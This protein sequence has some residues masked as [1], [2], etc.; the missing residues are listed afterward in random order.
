MSKRGGK[1]LVD[2][3]MVPAAVAFSTPRQIA[4]FREVTDGGALFSSI[5]TRMEFI[6]RWVS[7][8]ISLAGMAAQYRDV[9]G[10]F[11]Y[12]SQSFSPRD[13]K[14]YIQMV[15]DGWED[16]KSAKSTA[17]LSER[18]ALQAVGL[19]KRFEKRMAP[20]VPNKCGCQIGGLKLKVDFNAPM[21]DLTAFVVAFE[22][23]VRDCAINRFLN[24]QNSV[25]TAAKL[26]SHTALDKV[27]AVKALREFREKDKWI[28]CKECKQIGDVIIALEQP[29]SLTL[30][31]GD[32]KSF[33]A[34]AAVL[35][36]TEVCIESVVALENEVPGQLWRIG[37][38]LPKSSE[39]P[40]SDPN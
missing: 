33:P 37:Q 2:T 13:L 3:S 4:R 9:S 16:L 18:F 1:F 39:T 34:I 19:M 12:I 29:K 35:G 26:I 36:K 40:S 6:R 21:K 24:L 14:S 11:T 20:G 27:D 30:I 28:T 7:P 5:Y 25:G 32:K 17:E 31:H 38:R 8:L 23:V 15:G 10:F 22:T